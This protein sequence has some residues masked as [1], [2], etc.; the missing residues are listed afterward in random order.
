MGIVQVIPQKKASTP[1][2]RSGSLSMLE[3]SVLLF[4]FAFLAHEVGGAK[5]NEQQGTAA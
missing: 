4:L 1:W 2:R 5:A 3:N